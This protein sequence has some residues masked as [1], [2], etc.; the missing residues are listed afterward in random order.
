[1]IFALPFTSRSASS[2]ASATSSR[3]FVMTARSASTISSSSSRWIRS[4]FSL[5]AL[6]TS[7]HSL[8][9]L[10][11]RRTVRAESPSAFPASS[12]LPSLLASSA[13]LA[14]VSVSMR[15]MLRS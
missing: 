11:Y 7:G 2:G 10:R 1:M 3:I 6:A 15:A 4:A 13:A 5:A 9:S 12:S 14:A 8:A